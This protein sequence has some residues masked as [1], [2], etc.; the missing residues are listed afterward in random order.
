MIDMAAD[1]TPLLSGAVDGEFY[2]F[3]YKDVPAN[4]DAASHYA[5]RGWREGRD[6]NAWFSTDSYMR[7]HPELFNSDVVPLL[8]YLAHHSAGDPPPEPS[9]LAD[10]FYARP[11]DTAPSGETAGRPA[12]VASQ[13]ELA[14]A[15]GELGEAWRA[16]YAEFDSAYYYAKYPDVLG[17][18]A[19][20]HFVQQG[21]RERRNPNAWFNVRH[22]LE[23]NPDVE[24]AGIN[25]FLHYLVAGRH[26]K[27][28]LSLDL[29]YRAEILSDVTT[30]EER[31]ANLLP[32]SEI[33]TDPTANLSLALGNMTRSG[34]R[35]IH[36]SVS[37]DD[38]TATVGGLQLCLHREATG[39]EQLGVDH[40]HL[41]PARPMLF[42]D[43]ENSDPAVGVLIN[44]VR[45]GIYRIS[46][47]ADVLAYA[48]SGKFRQKSLA[49]H[50]TL[51]HNVP[52]LVTLLKN[53]GATYGFFWVHDFAA[54]CAGHNLLRD[55]VEFCGAPA[56]DS[57]A[58]NLCIYGARRSIQVADHQLLFSELD[59]VVAAP[60][61]IT[62]DTWMRAS[63]F[64]AI[65][66][67]VHPHCTF[68]SSRMITVNNLGDRPLRVAYLG[69][70]HTH[71][72]W[73][74]FRDLALRHA[75]D[76]R[77]HFFHLGKFEEIGLPVHFVNVEV[78]A[79][80]PRAMLDAV[81]EHEIDVAIIWSLCPETFSFVGHEAIAGGAYVIA[82]RS[83]GNL[84]RLVDVSG[85]GVTLEDESDLFA[86]FKSGDAYL[87]SRQVRA[88][89]VS[90]LRYSNLTA[91]FMGVPA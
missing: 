30:P 43:R 12:P 40:I 31:I 35:A 55:D 9:S 33:V 49:I 64:P 16:C 8:H 44:G 14:T 23:A 82:P 10:L 73:P 4:V 28:K 71:K 89:E 69:F 53:V 88:A 83:S 91:D 61:E 24:A 47:L 52:A 26:E 21:W 38:Y 3:A 29:G 57:A 87:F 72:G 77:Y 68:E 18:D 65:D 86:L 74:V 66:H 63:A 20:A 79:E 25:P 27:R 5:T 39:F 51:G 17:V 58:C 84:G 48:V 81:A 37:H 50:S 76:S 78:G 32:Q 59:L 36:V 60:A 7:N 15:A 54:I 2:R 19:L 46:E 41:F 45:C 80:N 90:D 22:Y 70:P 34:H 42:T 6:P 85:K 11:L 56:A 75:R 67:V 13:H 62:L 1:L